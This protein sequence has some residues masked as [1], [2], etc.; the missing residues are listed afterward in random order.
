[1]GN[2]GVLSADL[3]RQIFL[4]AQDSEV[5][6]RFLHRPLPKFASPD[7]SECLATMAIVRPLHRVAVE[8]RIFASQ[9]Q[10]VIARASPSAR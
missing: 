4:E 9:Q 7:E 5:V 3:S 1:V 6:G 2:R 8:L 10:D